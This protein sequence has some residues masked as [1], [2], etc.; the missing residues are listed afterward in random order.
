LL[1]LVKSKGLGLR[2]AAIDALGDMGPAGQDAPLLD[3][4][5]DENAGVRLHAALALAVSA[6]QASVGVLLERLTQAAAEDRMAIGVALSGALSRSTDASAKQVERV[7]FETGGGVRDALVEGLGRMPGAAAGNLIAALAR[8]RPDVADRRKIA[9]ALAGHPE[10]FAIL[11]DLLRDPDASV[12]AEAIWSAGYLSKGAEAATALGRAL[13]LIADGDLDVAANAAAA[14]ALLGKT[15][16]A[17]DP[18]AKSR[19]V[20]ALCKATGDF[21]SYVRANALAGLNL[22]A[23]RCDDG[24]LERRL[25]SQDPSE[26]VRQAAARLIL[27]V[28]STDRAKGDA[29]ALSRCVADDKSGLVANACRIAFSIPSESSPTLVFVVPD[30]KTSPTPLAAYSFLRA[31]G[32]IRSGLADRRGAIFERACP[33]GEFRLVVPGALAL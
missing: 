21:R 17:T 26:M 29:R 12:R 2:V 31:D 1:P 10:Q 3:A 22:L 16:A 14:S 5:D 7:L 18:A 27:R 33:R 11:R 23:A 13:E 32:L 8:R 20:A 19:A 15:A 6:G 30:G 28:P 4:L 9:E 25:L 24:G